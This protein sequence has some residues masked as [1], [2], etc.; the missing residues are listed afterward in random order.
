MNSSF[1]CKLF[2]LQTGS[3]DTSVRIWKPNVTEAD[4]RN[5]GNAGYGVTDVAQLMV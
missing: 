3:A 1:R 2:G 4:A 5:G